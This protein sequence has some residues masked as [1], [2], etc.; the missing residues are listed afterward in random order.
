MWGRGGV[1]DNYP[2]EEYTEVGNVYDT[3]RI[4]ERV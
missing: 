2:M 1:A 4:Q 3:N